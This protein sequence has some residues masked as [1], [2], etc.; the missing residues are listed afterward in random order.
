MIVDPDWPIVQPIS[1]TAHEARRKVARR[2]Q[3]L[4]AIDWAELANDAMAAFDQETCLAIYSTRGRQLRVRDGNKYR[5]LNQ[6]EY[7]ALW[8]VVRTA[9]GG[10]GCKL[11]CKLISLGLRAASLMAEMPSEVAR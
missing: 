5:K 8:T 3:R 2:Q 9:I 10:R 7:A 4:I 1:K 6:H 11:S